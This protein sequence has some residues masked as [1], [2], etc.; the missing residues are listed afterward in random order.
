MRHIP[1]HL[2]VFAQTFGGSVIVRASSYGKTD[3]CVGKAYRPLG[4]TLGSVQEAAQRF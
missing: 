3:N 2:A 4:A 1:N